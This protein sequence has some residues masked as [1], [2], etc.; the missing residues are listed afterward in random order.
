[1]LFRRHNH[2]YNFVA[3]PY[4]GLTARWGKTLDDDP[5]FAP[6]PELADISIS[7]HCTAECDFCY[8]E[9][10]PNHEFMSLK[11]YGF[12]LS[13]LSHKKW[14]TIFQVALGGGEPLEHP[15]F[16]EIVDATVHSGVVPNFT[17]NGKNITPGIA[18]R[19]MGKVGAVA[20]SVSDFQKFPYKT[21]KYLADVGVTTNI[22]F[23]LRKRSLQQAIEFLDGQYDDTLAGIN[24]VIFLTYKA[25][26]RAPR[27]DCLCWNEELSAFVR[28]I[29]ANRSTVR[30]GF[31]ACFVPVL[32]HSTR[33][34]M[35]LIDVC[36]C[37]FFSIYIDENLNVKPCSFTLGPNYCFSLRQMNFEQIWTVGLQGYRESFSNACK[38]HCITRAACRG[39]C[40][41]F[42]EINFCFSPVTSSTLP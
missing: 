8:R 12:I 25:A 39:G 22:H 4:T 21:V 9:S 13:E 40:P 38:R 15:N 42:P 3:N 20:I 35:R 1:M 34:D 19:L 30:V 27:H 17:T 6:W 41:Y 33:V 5:F 37:G 16:F 2:D 14:G 31:D 11:D 28:A 10:S 24:A 18:K 36:E 26:G 7:N 29:D 32:L 23:L